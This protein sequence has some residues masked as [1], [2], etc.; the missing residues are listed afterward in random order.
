MLLPNS[1]Q[2]LG[3]YLSLKQAK[4]DVFKHHTEEHSRDLKIGTAV[5]PLLCFPFPAAEASGEPCAWHGPLGTNTGAGE[6]ARN[7]SLRNSRDADDPY[8][9]K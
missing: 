3:R 5:A 8:G 2:V 7:L 9:R 1:A 4:P 6:A